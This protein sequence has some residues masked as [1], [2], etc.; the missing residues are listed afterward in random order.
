MTATRPTPSSK[1]LFR[2]G[3][4]QKVR[5][6]INICGARRSSAVGS[7][8][9]SGIS[10]G[11]LDRSA[12]KPAFVLPR[13]TSIRSAKQVGNRNRSQEPGARSQEFRSSGVQE[14]RSSGVQKLGSS[15]RI[16]ARLLEAERKSRRLTVVLVIVIVFPSA[17][18]KVRARLKTQGQFILLP[19]RPVSSSLIVMSNSHLGFQRIIRLQK[20]QCQ[21]A[22]A[23]AGH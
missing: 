4:A 19:S 7:A 6:I 23:S 10:G 12:M 20:C 5:N 8:A 1:I 16:L 21:I 17:T 2:C 15:G 3:E 22:G 13:L 14:F 18:I 9:G 11:L